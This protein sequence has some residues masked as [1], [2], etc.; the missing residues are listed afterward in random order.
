METIKI[1]PSHES[2]GEFVIINKEDF[3]AGKH[4]LFDAELVTDAPKRRGRPAK[5]EAEPAAE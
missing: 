1:K 2:Q 3:D 4:E 5:T